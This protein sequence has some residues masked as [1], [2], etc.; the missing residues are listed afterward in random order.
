MRIPGFALSIFVAAV[1]VAGCG[2]DAVEAG[3]RPAD[4]GRADVVRDLDGLLRSGA[5]GVLATVTANGETTVLT[6]GLADTAAGTAIRADRPEYVRIGSVTKTFTA[7]IVLQLAAERRVDLDRSV[8]TYL[9]GLL[10]GDGID[11]RAI[12]VRQILGHRSGLPE[13]VEPEGLNEY[14]AARAG[15]TY[16][17][18]Q[19]VALAL[20]HPATF[21]PGARFE[22]ANINYLVAGM[23]IEAVT[24]HRYADELRDRIL[25]PLGLSDT[26]LPATGETGLREPHLTGYGTVDG[27]VTDQTQIEPSMPWTSGAL[28]STGADLNRFFTAL[29]AEQVVPQAQLRQMLDGVDMGNGDGM[30]YGLG[31]G[32]AQ[33]PCGA[34]FVGNVGGVPGFTAVAGAT[35]SGRAVTFSYT[36][37][38]ADADLGGLL[39]HALCG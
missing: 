25:T 7:A 27:I 14:T 21:A 3:A 23:L 12:T 24:G 34:Q 13:P 15:R 37:T 18:A 19:E 8:D 2:A 22:Y 36:G 39:S 5:V 32:Y 29:L 16:T 28:V 10:V 9:P 17:P 1:L 38:V 20:Q 6:A 11:G 26:Y 33:L 35:S 4:G 31:V 30:S